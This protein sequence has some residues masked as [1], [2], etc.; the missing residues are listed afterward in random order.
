MCIFVYLFRAMPEYPHVI[1]LAD[2]E[3][4]GSPDISLPGDDYPE[5]VA[6]PG[7]Q[8]ILKNGLPATEGPIKDAF[9]TWV[10]G[11]ALVSR[12]ANGNVQE[13]LGVDMAASNWRWQIWSASAKSTLYVWV[14]FGFSLVG[15]AVLRRQQEQNEVIR[16][17]SEAIE[18]SHTAVMIIDLQGRIEY[19]N[20]GFCSQV[21]HSRRD[22]IGKP[23]R[24]YIRETIPVETATD[25]AAIFYARR[26]WS[27]EWLNSRPDGS[28][29]PVRGII[30]AVRDRQDQVTCFVA[31]Y[32][33]LSEVRRNETI[34]REAKEQAEAG[35]RAKSHF[36]ATMSHEVRTPLNGIVGFTNLLLETP[37][38]AEQE[39]YMRTIRSS[40]EAL[41][42]LTNDI[43]DSARIETGKLKLDLQP[44]DP[45]ECLE[46]ALDMMAT[47]AS[48]KNIELLYRIDE[49]VPKSVLTDM[50]RLRQVLLNLIGN[51]V[52][53]TE[54]GDVMIT[55]QGEPVAPT[56]D[57]PKGQRA[58]IFTVKDTGIGIDPAKFEKLF[59]PF[60]Q[61]ETSSTRRYNGAGLGLAISSNLV[62]LMGGSMKVESSVGS[63]STFSFSIIAEEVEPPASKAIIPP[64]NISGV[65]V[66]IAAE[67]GILRDELCRMCEQWGARITAC[68]PEEL[69]AQSW[70]TALVNITDKLAKELI[71]SHGLPANLPRE[72]LIA[73]VPLGLSPANRAALRPYFRL[74]V[75]KPA[76]HD[77][78]RSALATPATGTTPLP[79]TNINT[80]DLQ[81]LL[82]EDNPVNQ[83]LMQK[84]LGHFG[85]QWTVAENGRIALDELKRSD[86]HLVLMDLHMPEMD[87]Y[88]AIQKIRDGSGGE[89][90]RHVWITALTADARAEQKERVMEAGANDYLLKPVRLKDMEA[91]MR[92]FN[93]HRSGEAPTES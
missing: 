81:V 36:L 8:S 89:N 25:I 30:T 16:N 55:V 87:G 33:D 67:A 80:F 65:R 54:S 5:A 9:G 56:E 24:E 48:E 64:H 3:P 6:S 1:F 58:V 31:N 77:A 73:L 92:R 46:D 68:T 52:K 14:L 18:Q 29:Y 21:G 88:T 85:C 11:Y 23:W 62:Q 61:L 82:V 74:L 26:N 86:Y 49:S 35:D 75:N 28:S 38:N 71:Q 10:T 40:G 93:A 45:R 79:F 43:L 90:M 47:R 2:S 41:I 66:A 57:H 83:L 76:H 70:D 44:T 32:E 22:L 7:L 72:K 4:A 19:A 12:D 42:Q 63:G 20:Q 37:L 84:V 60:S 50:G 13:V 59:R 69:P 78:L 27:G 91:M 53:F 39:E 51:A 17:L 15:Y 34:L